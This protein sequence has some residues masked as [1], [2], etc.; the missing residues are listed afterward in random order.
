MVFRSRRAG[1]SDV[2]VRHVRFM[3]IVLWAYGG[4]AGLESGRVTGNSAYQDRP[5]AKN[6]LTYQRRTACLCNRLKME[7]LASQSSRHKKFALQV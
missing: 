1:G 2:S 7:F 3:L 6:N 4:M 5:H